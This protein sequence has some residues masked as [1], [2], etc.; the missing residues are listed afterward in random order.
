MELRAQ[1]ADFDTDK[2]SGS[3][4]NR[5]VQFTNQS[6]AASISTSFTFNGG[7]L[8][9]GWS[10]SPFSVGSPCDP[11]DGPSPDNT[12]YFWATTTDNNGNRFVQTNSVD[13]NL[14]GTLEYLFR[15]G[16]DDPQPGCEEADPGE[17]VDI[18]Y[19][20][21]GG[22]TWTTIR[23]IDPTQARVWTKFTDN[24]PAGAQTTS[25]IFRWIQTQNSGGQ[26]DNWGLEDLSVFATTTLS[27]TGYSWNFGDGNSSTAKDP[28]HTF[29]ATPGRTSYNVSLTVSY[30]N[31]TT[32]NKT[33]AY[34]IFNDNV[35]PTVNTNNIVLPLDA[36]GQ[37][38]IVPAD[39]D[40]GST[41]NCS[42]DNLSLNV[43]DFDCNDLGPNTVTLTATDPSSNRANATATVTVEDNL[44]PTVVTQDITVQLDAN[45]Q[46]TIVPADINN[47][48]T[49]NCAIDNLSLNVTDFDCNDVGPNPVTLTATDRSSNSAN[50]TATVT[51]EDNLAPTVVTQDITVQLDANGQATIVASDIDNG[52]TDNCVID[53]L[54]LDVTD[55]D[56][57]DV[58]PN[59]VTLTATDRSSNSANATATVTV[60]DNIA[61]TVLTQDL[62]V[63]LDANGQATINPSDIDNGSTDNCAI[64]SLSLDVTSFGCIDRGARTVTLTAT[65]PSNNTAT[66]TATVTVED[67]TDPV[68]TSFPSDIR[69]CEE[70]DAGAVVTYTT[71]TASDNCSAFV[72]LVGGPSSG[73]RLGAG[74]YTVTFRAQ[75]RAGNF[76][77][78]SFTITV[79]PKPEADFA[80]T[81]ACQS[82][83]TFFTDSTKLAS[84]SITSFAWTFGEGGSSSKRNPL[85]IY[86]ASGS[87]TTELQV[88]SDRGCRDTVQKPVAVN[89]LPTVDF[90]VNPVCE[91]ASASFVNN[92]QVTGGGLTYRWDFGDGQTSTDAN[93]SH[94]Y[95]ASGFYSVKLIATSPSGCVDSVTKRLEIYA[96]PVPA[97]SFSDACQDE[98][99]SFSNTSRA[100]VNYN[101]D[102]GDGQT[103]TMTDPDHVY[104]S[105][106]SFNVSLE[107]ISA[108]GCRET[109]T[110]TVQIFQL[111]TAAFTAANVCDGKEMQFANASQNAS[112][113]AWD[114]G[115]G[116]SATSANPGHTYADSGDF[117]VTL[118]ATSAQGCRDT[119]ENQTVTVDPLPEVAWTAVAVCE[120]DEQTVF[121]NN[122]L[123][124]STF[125]WDFGDGQSSTASAP[126]YQYAAAG[127]YQ[128]QLTAT[129][130][131]GCVDSLRQPVTVHPKPVAA[132]TAQDECDGDA[133]QFSDQSSIS[134]GNLSYA[135][136]FGDMM[137]ASANASPSYTYA[138]SGTYTAQLITTS[139]FGCGDTTSAQ[140]E[141]FANPVAAFSAQNEC[142]GDTVD[143]TNNSTGAT[144][145]AWQ[146]GNRSS[147]TDF[148][149]ERAY[150]NAGTYT[151]NLTA[152]STEGCVDDTSETVTVYALP[153]AAFTAND[154]CAEDD[155][156]FTDNLSSGA[157]QYAW[158]LGAGNSSSMFEPS[159]V[160]N[161]DGQYAFE[162]IATSQFGCRDTAQRTVTVFVKPSA[163]FTAAD[164]CDGKEMQ[165]TN[166]SQDASSYA[167][168]F[169]D[170]A[171]A[172]SANPGHTYADSGDFDVTLIATSAQGC[173]DTVENQTVTVDPLP[174]VAWTA[175]AVC[176]TDEQTVFVNNSLRGSSFAWT[177]GDGQG[178]NTPAPVYQYAGAG[179]YRA[180]LTV[181]TVEGCV[182][183]LRQPVTVHPKPE[184][185]FTQEDV[186]AEAEMPFDNTSRGTL[187]AYAW[188]FDGAGASTERDPSFVFTS[189]GSPQVQ[190]IV[191]S[192]E[193][194]RDTVVQPVEVF[195]LPQPAFSAADVCHEEG[196]QYN[197]A[198]TVSSGTLSY[199]WAF[200]EG[201]SSSDENPLYT[202][203][204]PGNYVTRLTATTDRGCVRSVEGGVRV[205]PNPVV[206]F[207]F[208]EVCEGDAT[209]FEAQ[210]SV[211]TGTIAAYRWQMGDGNDRSQADPAYTYATDGFY[212]VRLEVETDQ[213]CVDDVQRQVEVYPTPEAVFT[214]TT[215][216]FGDTTAFTNA[217]IDADRYQWRFGDATGESNFENP[218]Y[219]YLNPGDYTTR[220]I[221]ENGDGCRDTTEEIVT[222][223]QLPVADFTVEDVCIDFNVEPV[224]QSIGEVQEWSWRFGDG[225]T[226]TQRNPSVGYNQAGSYTISLEVVDQNL[227]EDSTQMMV[228]IFALPEMD[229]TTDTTLSQGD[230]LRL[231][232]EGGTSYAWTP[233]AGLSNTQVRRPLARP[234]ENTTYTVAVTTDRGC[235]DD[236][237][238]TLNVLRDFTLRPTNMFTPD[239]NGQN[240]TWVIG[241]IDIYEGCRVVI[242]NQWGQEVY[243]TTSYQNDWAGTYEGSELPD[244]TYY[245]IIDCPEGGK[246]YKGAITILRGT[247]N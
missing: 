85:Y 41:D 238:V 199:Q 165:F 189:A 69:L 242:F 241:N 182:D 156:V 232:A 212:D 59:P 32:Q 146:F 174:E 91:G 36:N 149:P 72:N 142:L 184:A 152:T 79:D 31:S 130:T 233:G 228:E 244:G 171:S 179:T 168:D 77:N 167:W 124:A 120:T 207:D 239:G 110:Q 20:T 23:T 129:T 216:C 193:D 223:H 117:D 113:Y 45:G 163:A 243:Q 209:P 210:A 160:F 105:N 60:E 222:V 42:I 245:Y 161:Q 225:Q 194:C 143:F 204:D 66:A 229:V 155:T 115:D 18:Q 177:F 166:A 34:E 35:A 56:C 126:V 136:D 123:R 217:S 247:R 139:G 86:S 195:P 151:V 122:S 114:F 90:R 25:T 150:A 121:V 70:T 65:D 104:T 192:N 93:P 51:V 63:Y 24:I 11:P 53:N 220:L 144:S 30:S 107:A 170:G 58:G 52:S 15:F 95:A 145:Y 215:V 172:T 87:Y 106:G 154:A 213:G 29:P 112:S 4:N 164:V 108:D 186:C 230:T 178:S 7:N 236:T 44:A 234:L 118:I 127:S 181:T 119:V 61:P 135:W 246:D 98:T 48:S 47:G 17:G 68:F 147:S 206:G 16:N 159:R 99:V 157:N 188:D 46:A 5:T 173:R 100:A 80:N 22:S 88:E 214:A 40:N 82:E 78:R 94:I 200:G 134:A 153:E 175:D 128:A 81:T 180:Q 148:E 6:T 218:V 83:A 73:L 208:E 26:F 38:T 12:S 141:V 240:D 57:N 1:V 237:T 205:H 224:D 202:F 137:G 39:I 235:T 190:L 162:L 27:I 187:T 54:S 55:F 183:S 227:C 226:S 21:N 92:S 231:R 219:T 102:F 133:I 74:T 8:P 13:V 211:S 14:G 43:T 169:G 221:A 125:A 37:A 109:Q 158:T 49:D 75:D 101:W 111:P 33:V 131:Q 10:S 132:F 103:S 62:T 50:A 2:P 67:T 89:P 97:F 138:S 198:T 197:N 76:V 84:G 201:G 196:T 140:V 96:K 185:S 9:S 116:A 3:C 191:T 203:E 64:A 176:E 19:S 28:T 71:P